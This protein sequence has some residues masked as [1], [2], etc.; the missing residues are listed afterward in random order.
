MRN[1]RASHHFKKP[2]NTVDATRSQSQQ[3]RTFFSIHPRIKKASF[4]L[5]LLIHRHLHQHQ[6]FLSDLCLVWV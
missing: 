5:Y 3:A 1:E 6:H 4:F 2:S